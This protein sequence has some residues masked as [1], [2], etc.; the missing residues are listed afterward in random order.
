MTSI[1][2]SLSKTI[3]LSL[4]LAILLFLA[5]LEFKLLCDVIKKFALISGKISVSANSIFLFMF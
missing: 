2:Q 4:G 3:H 5:A 1:L